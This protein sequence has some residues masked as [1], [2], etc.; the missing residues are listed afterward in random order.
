MAVIDL[1]NIIRPKKIYNEKTLIN[2]VNTNF[3]P[4]YVDLHLDMESSKNIGLGINASNTGDILVDYDLE[5]VKNSIRN[6]FTTKKGQKLLNPDFGVSLDQFLFTQLTVP[7][8]KAIANEI[9]RGVSKYESRIDITNI[10]VTPDFNLNLYK[11]QIFYN[12][13]D[14][15]K[16]NIINITAQIGGQLSF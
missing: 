16:Q 10:Y 4:T 6:I 9:L 3:Y 7:N 8:A 15:N 12:M 14:I 13:K 11:I 2:D 5:A 1:N